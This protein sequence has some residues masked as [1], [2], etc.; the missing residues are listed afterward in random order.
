MKGERLNAYQ[1]ALAMTEK[2]QVYHLYTGSF[3][4]LACEYSSLFDVYE[5]TQFD[6]KKHLNFD[7][8]TLNR[9]RAHHNRFNRQSPLTMQFAFYYDCQH[10]TE[11]ERLQIVKQFFIKK[12]ELLYKDELEL[13]NSLKSGLIEGV[14]YELN[15]EKIK[16]TRKL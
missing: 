4:A 16:E 12:M 10:E 2:K 7:L 14:H 13:I 5:A 15:I 1:K 8:N 11:E 9:L 3:K 6:V